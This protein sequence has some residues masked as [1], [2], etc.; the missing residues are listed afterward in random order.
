MPLLAGPP[1]G[2]EPAAAFAGITELN[3]VP[4]GATVAN[5]IGNKIVMKSVHLK[6]TLTNTALAGLATARVMLLYDSQPNGAF[7]AYTDIMLEQ[8]LGAATFHGNLNIANKSRFQMI[9]DSFL[10]FDEAQANIRTVNLYCKGRWQTE[11]GG[12]AGTIADFRTGA[13]F[14]VA[15]CATNVVAMSAGS[16]RIRYYD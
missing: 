8:P 15:L 10:N 9:R 14:L 3:C 2:A 1:S 16:A 5:R 4:Q 12:N 11:F 7:P 13:L 6:F